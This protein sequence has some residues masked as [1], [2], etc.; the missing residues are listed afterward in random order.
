MQ[1]VIALCPHNTGVINDRLYTKFCSHLSNLAKQSIRCKC[2]L[3]NWHES[4]SERGMAREYNINKHDK[5]GANG[6]K[7]S[8][9]WHWLHMHT[10]TRNVIRVD[11]IR[12]ALNAVLNASVITRLMPN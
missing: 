2:K 1:L 6:E 8:T 7:L 12:T 4:Q 3:V 5:T 10:C 9:D 11:P